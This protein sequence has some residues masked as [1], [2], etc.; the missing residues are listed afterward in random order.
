MRE[1]IFYGTVSQIRFA[2]PMSTDKAPSKLATPAANRCAWSVVGP[3]FLQIF[4]YF[5]STMTT[6]RG[7]SNPRETTRA[8]TGLRDDIEMTLR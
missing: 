8:K 5:T 4:E 2:L 1:R 3:I 7:Q 6:K